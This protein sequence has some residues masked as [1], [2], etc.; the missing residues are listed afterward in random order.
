MVQA[1]KQFGRK[2]IN[3]DSENII[4]IKNSNGESEKYQLL[5]LIE[6]TSTRKRMTV[7]IKDSSGKIKIMC[8]GAD[9]IIIERLA[10]TSLN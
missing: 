9:S 3:R 1:A 2:F 4:E 7:I 5:E 10:E 6:F 8:K